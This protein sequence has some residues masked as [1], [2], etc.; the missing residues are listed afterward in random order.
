MHNSYFFSNVIKKHDENEKK[1]FS[2][3]TT[4]TTVFQYFKLKKK[5]YINY[6]RKIIHRKLM[7][8]VQTI[9]FIRNIAL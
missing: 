9:E 2:R 7:I 6:S 3:I 8:Y 1:I 5:G 4:Q